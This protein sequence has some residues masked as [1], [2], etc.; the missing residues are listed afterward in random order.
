MV[1]DNHATHKT[2]AAKNWLGCHPLFRP[3]FTPTSASW[4]ILVERWFA[5]LTIRELRRSAHRSIVAL[6]ADIRTLSGA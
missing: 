2:P 6:E 4:M 5:E 3:H 1:P